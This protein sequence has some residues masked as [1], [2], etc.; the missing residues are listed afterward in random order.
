MS[1]EDKRNMLNNLNNLI[2]DNHRVDLSIE[3]IVELK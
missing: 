1:V 2:E 3:T